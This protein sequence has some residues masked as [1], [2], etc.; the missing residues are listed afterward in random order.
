MIEIAVRDSF[1]LSDSTFIKDTHTEHYSTEQIRKELNVI[2]REKPPYVDT[3]P[4]KW[5]KIRAELGEYRTNF[6]AHEKQSMEAFKNLM[7]KRYNLENLKIYPSYYYHN[8]FV[9]VKY[10]LY[11]LND[12]Y[13]YIYHD[14]FDLDQD[15]PIVH[16]MCEIAIR[17]ALSLNTEELRNQLNVDKDKLK[18]TIFAGYG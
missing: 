12:R 10:K 8:N 14:I 16:K 9:Q 3:H 2:G 5:T 4:I 7:K 11:G 15:M 18:K 17:E 1:N 13:P 6:H